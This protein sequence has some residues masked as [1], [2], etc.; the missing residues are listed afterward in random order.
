MM[1]MKRPTKKSMVLRVYHKG[2]SRQSTDDDDDGV[3]R[4]E[5]VGIEN[6]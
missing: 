3:N 5:L 6:K 1:M 4:D 2:R